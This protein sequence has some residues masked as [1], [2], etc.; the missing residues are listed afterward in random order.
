MRGCSRI[1]PGCG[2]ANGGGCYAE[3]IAGRFSDPGQPFHGFAE[4]GPN[5]ARW[6]R[7]VS[8]IDDQ[9]D[10]PIHWK[11]PRL[12]FVNSMSDTFH[13]DLTN[14]SIADVFAVMAACPRHRFQVLTKRAARMAEFLPWLYAND[15]E[16]L[17]AAGE[18]LATRMGWC[19]ANEHEWKLP[20]PNVWLGVSVEDAKRADERIPRLLAC[21]AAVKFL[22]VEPLLEDVTERIRAWLQPPCDCCDVAPGISWVIV[23]GESG[24]NARPFNIAWARGVVDACKEAGVPVFV[25][26]LGAY[27]QTNGIVTPDAP[28]W[29]EGTKTSEDDLGPGLG[30][31]WRVHLRD[32]KGG[33]MAEWPADLRVREMPQAV[34][35]GAS[36]EHRT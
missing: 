35:G 19:H 36:L 3:Q 18:R 21:P 11:G 15:G 4:R 32:R 10:T 31:G 7:K 13:E 30:L 33:D 24:N 34:R 14:E 28:G 6:T 29:P 25:K 9:I 22:S 8:L 20:L 5:G 16:M 12:I 23:G 17:R 2:G 27:V 1:S 26:Q